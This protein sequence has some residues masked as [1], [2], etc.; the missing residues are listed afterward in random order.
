MVVYAHRMGKPLKVE[1][2]GVII[3]PTKK[4][5]ESAAVLNP[6]AYQEGEFVHL[7]YRAIDA[8]NI[9]SIGYAKLKG[10]TEVIE[11]WNQPILWPEYEHESKG[12]EDPRI[13]KID[14]TFYLTYIAHDGKNALIAYAEGRDLKHLQKKGIISPKILYDDAARMFR[15]EKLKDRYFMFESFY[16]EYAG[17]QVLLWEKDGFLF[18]KKIKGK[19][20]M[21]H[22]ILPD[23]HIV[24]F[25]TFAQL[26]QKNFWKQYFR[27]LA[28]YVVLENKYWFE[29]R[30]VGGG[31]PPIETKLGWLLIFHTVEELNKARIYHASAALLDKKNPLKV[32]GRLDYPLFSPDQKWEKQ[33]F[34]SNVVFPTGTAIFGKYLYIYYGAADM[35]IA[36]ARV[37]LSRLLSELKSKHL[38]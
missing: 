16:E 15:K 34:V 22:R 29:S 8:N 21:I 3:E 38:S 12:L 20:A 30:Q 37:D 28:H 14:K 32:I 33:G 7:F 23:V 27:K 35:R 2:L 4:S 31:A 11:R 6:A 25:K 1:K 13:V 26:K 36:A 9:S 10:P 19:F 24:Y 18:P 17:K 5:F